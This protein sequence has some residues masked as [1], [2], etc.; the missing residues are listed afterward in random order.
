MFSRVYEFLE[1]SNSFYPLQFGFRK[2]H[3]TTHALIDIIEKINEALDKK[4][5]ACGIFVDFQKAFDTV[6]HEI[7]IKKTVAPWN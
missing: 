7:L 5:I 1:N 6:N 4:K 2:R 3:S